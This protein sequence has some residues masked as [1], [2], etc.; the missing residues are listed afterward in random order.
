MLDNSAVTNNFYREFQRNCEE[1]D[2]SQ[3]WPLTCT[4]RLGFK[5]LFSYAGT[6]WVG[7]SKALLKTV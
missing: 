1:V 6:V 3:R 2:D 5:C 4:Q 7:I